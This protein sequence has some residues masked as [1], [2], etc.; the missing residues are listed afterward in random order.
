MLAT[1][2]GV[3][4]LGLGVHTSTAAKGPRVSDELD[5]IGNDLNSV[6]AYANV[7]IASGAMLLVT[8]PILYVESS[9][10]ASRASP[11]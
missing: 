9:E 8:T 5:F 11:S 2:V 3:I 10:P 6:T 1:I 7:G 4:V